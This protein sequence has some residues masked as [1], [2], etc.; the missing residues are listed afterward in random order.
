MESKINYLRENFKGTK[1]YIVTWEH[2]YLF[3]EDKYIYFLY[4]RFSGL[5]DTVLFKSSKNYMYLIELYN[6]FMLDKEY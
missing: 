3:K 6:L 1:N 5:H 4:I 2:S